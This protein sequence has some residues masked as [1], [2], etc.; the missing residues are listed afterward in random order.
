LK[1]LSS[2]DNHRPSLAENPTRAGQIAGIP[3]K[4]IK[5]TLEKTRPII[6]HDRK[7]NRCYSLRD[8]FL[9]AQID[10]GD[11]SRGYGGLDPAG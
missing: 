9:R 5:S 4:L 1:Y 3:W 6:K 10:Q 7:E 11:G 2:I 8:D